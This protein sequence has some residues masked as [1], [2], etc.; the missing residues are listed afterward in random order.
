M[1][2][3][4]PE[5][6]SPPTDESQTSP[7][8]PQ[9]RDVVQP[10][11]DDLYPDYPEELDE[12]DDDAQPTEWYDE[13]GRR[14][15]RRA[16]PEGTEELLEKEA[17]RKTGLPDS[18]E[19]WRQRS[20][21]G[22]VVTAMALGLQAAL[23]TERQEPAIVMETSGDPPTDLPVEAQLEQ[24]GPR[25]STV[26]VRRWLLTGGLDP[27]AQA[28]DPTAQ[29]EGPA[30]PSTAAPAPQSAGNGHA[31]QQLAPDADGGETQAP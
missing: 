9:A 2:Q 30:G 26:T 3:E 16:A 11:D 27:E 21:A 29:A 14:H 8:V 6:T 4:D 25:Q 24:L 15:L 5:G 1:A 12:Q 31:Q 19:R 7:A 28:D 13:Q 20:A 22:A 23:E 17:P 10:F 18:I